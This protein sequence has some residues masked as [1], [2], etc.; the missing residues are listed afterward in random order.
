M[1]I[2]FKSMF[3]TMCTNGVP[4]KHIIIILLFLLR[5]YLTCHFNITWWTGWYNG[6]WS[7][8]TL[9]DDD[10]ST[11]WIWIAWGWIPKEHSVA[12]CGKDVRKTHIW[13]CTSFCLVYCTQWATT[14]AEASWILIG[15]H[16]IYILLKKKEKKKKR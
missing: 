16:G 5:F 6:G 10:G 14:F 9:Y 4:L 7:S 8:S 1:L 13:T 3:K 12:T 15:R 11:W 2:H